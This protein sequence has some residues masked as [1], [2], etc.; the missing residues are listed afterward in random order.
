MG[1]L[2]K[3]A[4][5]VIGPAGAIALRVEH[6]VFTLAKRAARPYNKPKTQNEN[7]RGAKSWTKPCAAIWSGL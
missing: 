1:D 5:P 7:R 3:S 4:N 6:A 2:G